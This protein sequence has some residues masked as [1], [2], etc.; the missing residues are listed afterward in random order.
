MR[1]R[2][3]FSASY[4][5]RGWKESDRRAALAGV[6]SSRAVQ[7]PQ[8]VRLNTAQ[9]RGAPIIRGHTA[10]AS[11]LRPLAQRIRVASRFLEKVS[12]ARDLGHAA[13]HHQ[14]N[15]KAVRE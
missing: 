4:S 14:P 9:I 2:A 3:A 12:V 1:A 7:A 11:E 13:P 8:S 10:R 5:G 15:L 6:H